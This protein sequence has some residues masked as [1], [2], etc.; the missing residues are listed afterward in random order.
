MGKRRGPVP[1]A[2]LSPEAQKWWRSVVAEYELEPHHLK[3]LEAAAGAWD[4]ITEARER[5]AQ[6]GAYV[7]DRFGVVKS[8]PAVIVERDAKATFARLLRELALDV[9]GPGDDSRP[10]GIAGNAGLRR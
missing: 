2:Y 8:H 5:I 3:V 7:L 6:D 9:S 10:P 1:P 4:R